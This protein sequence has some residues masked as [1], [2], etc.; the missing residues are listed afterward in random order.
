[1]FL[2][3]NFQKKKFKHRNEGKICE[4]AIC[5]KIIANFLL[6]LRCLFRGNLGQDTGQSAELRVLQQ[7]MIC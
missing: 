1:M 2:A 3:V 7:N 6:K 5:A 4:T